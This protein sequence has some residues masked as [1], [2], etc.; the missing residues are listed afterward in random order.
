MN[1]KR[2]LDVFLWKKFGLQQVV[3]SPVDFVLHR[4][5]GSYEGDCLFGVEFD[6][7]IYWVTIDD[8]GGLMNTTTQKFLI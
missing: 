1:I 8:G 2:K 5:V 3:I 4:I 6:K 7:V